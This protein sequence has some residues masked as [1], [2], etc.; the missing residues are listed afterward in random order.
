MIKP[1]KSEYPFCMVN[2]DGR[3]AVFDSHIE[4][5][6]FLELLCNTSYINKD[7]DEFDIVPYDKE[8]VARDGMI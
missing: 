8:D 6:D 4:A 7:M 2:I 1:R 3:W 5:E